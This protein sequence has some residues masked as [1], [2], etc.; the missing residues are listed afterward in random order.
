MWR[1]ISAYYYF[2]KADKILL[3]SEKGNYNKININYFPINPV[4]MFLYKNCKYDEYKH[5]IQ[6]VNIF[7]QSNNLLLNL[8][9]NSFAAL[10]FCDHWKK[11]ATDKL[12]A[13]KLY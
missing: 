6:Y 9:V 5:N 3:T 10:W 8:L 2:V 1:A 4:H 13:I 12:S 7:F 11:N